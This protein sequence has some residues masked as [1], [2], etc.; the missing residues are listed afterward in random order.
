MTVR[1]ERSGV[2]ALWALSV[3]AVFGVLAAATAARFANVRRSLELRERRLQADWLARSGVELARAKLADAT[4]DNGEATTEPFPGG[5]IAVKWARN[6]QAIH[7]QSE[8]RI[9][10]AGLTTTPTVRA[11]VR[12]ISEK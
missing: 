12:T 8:G 10:P 11:T 3:L 5:M 1:D 2:A 7:V 6:G 9:A 4:A